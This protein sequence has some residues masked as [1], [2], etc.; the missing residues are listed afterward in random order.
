M[1][2]AQL[3]AWGLMVGSGQ[4]PKFILQVL[5]NSDTYR[6][7]DKNQEFVVSYLSMQSK[8]KFMKTINHYD[9]GIDEIVASNLTHE[10]SKVLKTPR[11]KEGFAH[12]ECK[13]DWMK[14]VEDGVKVNVL[15]Q[16]SIVNAAIDEAVLS[17]DIQESY[18]KR[19]FVFDIQEMIN[20]KTTVSTENGIFTSLDIKNSVPI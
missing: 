1:A 7:I 10:A 18:K 14:D 3:N 5:N 11:I 19:N 8:E 12:F 16:G 6:L 2:N 9:D 15:I 17:D 20:P 13:L 4:E